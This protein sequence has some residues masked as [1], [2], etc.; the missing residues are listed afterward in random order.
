MWDP[1]R[2]LNALIRAIAVAAFNHKYTLAWEKFYRELK[3]RT[4]IHI[5]NR[6]AY[7]NGCALDAVREEE[8]PHLMKVAASLCYDYAVDV[9]YATNEETVRQYNLDTIETEFGIRHNQGM[10]T[11]KGSG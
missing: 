5:C 3:Y 2:T 7:S 9:V 10:K 6:A 4:G 1:R 8:W 11:W